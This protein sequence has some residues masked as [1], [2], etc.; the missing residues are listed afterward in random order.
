VVNYLFQE[1]TPVMIQ[2]TRSPIDDKTKE[3]FD[4]YLEIYGTNS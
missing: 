2:G 1:K 3:R 4:E